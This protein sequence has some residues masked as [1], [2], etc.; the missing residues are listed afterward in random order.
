[1][2]LPTTASDRPRRRS[3][4]T[5]ASR[6]AP[7]EITQRWGL[8]WLNRILI[9]TGTGVVLVAGLQAFITLQSI[10]VEQISV[11]GNL[12]HTR[13]EEVQALVQPALAGGFLN[14]DL[15]LIR[16]Q[17]EG[18]PWIY[19]A[20]VRRRWPSSLEINVIEQLPIARWG[21]AGFLNHEAEVFQTANAGDW[22]ALPL[23]VGPDDS[24]RQLMASYQRLE[25]LLAPLSLEVS[26]LALDHRNQ[27]TATLQG[28]TQLYLGGEDFV[29]RVQRLLTLYRYELS[30]RTAEVARVD[31]R[32]ES[33]LAVAFRAPVQVA[34]AA[35]NL[36][37]TGE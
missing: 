31:L 15:A 18:M 34:V 11:T 9:L 27:L 35:T 36:I 3:K 23:L 30:G 14:A 2:P 7:V 33:G 10:A 17:L 24:A 1:M 19:R 32:Y 20:T 16:Q 28:G 13:A 29:E 8:G 6:N 4:G 26:E 5:G 21:D 22:Q 25:E 37:S 12:Q